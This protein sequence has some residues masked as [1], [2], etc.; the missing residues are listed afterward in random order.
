MRNVETPSG[1]GPCRTGKPTVRKAQSPGGK[2]MVQEAN[3]G[4]R[5]ATGNRDRWP[6][7]PPVVSHNWPDTGRCPARKGA[8]VGQ[9]SLWRADDDRRRRNRRTSWTRRRTAAGVV[10][11]NGPEDDVLDW[12]AI[13]WRRVED[14]RTAS[15]AADLHGIAGTGTSKRVRSLQKLMLRSVPTRF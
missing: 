11:V 7:P 8:D 1:S 4:G 5:K 3:A 6:A 9:V 14:E 15:A 2:R 10:E 13:D 12:D